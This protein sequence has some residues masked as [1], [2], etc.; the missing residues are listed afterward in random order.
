[1][2][3][4]NKLFRDIIEPR[5]VDTPM[6]GSGGEVLAGGRVSKWEDGSLGQ[7][8]SELFVFCVKSRELFWLCP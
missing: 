8:R 7:I 5:S 1:M 6:L 3:S 2:R 4:G